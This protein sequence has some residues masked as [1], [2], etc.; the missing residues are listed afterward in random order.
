MEQIAC[1]WP[2]SWRHRAQKW[3]FEPP[4]VAILA[5]N[6]EN[7]CIRPVSPYWSYTKRRCVKFYILT[8]PLLF[9]IPQGVEGEIDYK[10][11]RKNLMDVTDN[12]R[13]CAICRKNRFVSEQ[14]D[15][16]NID[17]KCAGEKVHV[18]LHC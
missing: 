10:K 5:P 14:S 11:I 3:A 17:E 18:T 4:C 13:L 15:Q 16:K 1:S 12:S 7:G 6:A 8:H 2:I 9:G